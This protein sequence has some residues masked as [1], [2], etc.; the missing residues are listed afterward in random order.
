[1]EIKLEHLRMDAR[2]YRVLKASLESNDRGNFLANIATLSHHYCLGYC[3]DIRVYAAAT[4]A[5][6]VFTANMPLELNS[7]QFRR[8]IGH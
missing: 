1:M 4:T 8:L 2:A 7:S 3:S 6:T 5:I